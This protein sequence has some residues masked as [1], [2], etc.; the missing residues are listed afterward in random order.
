M[1]LMSTGVVRASH[2]GFADSAAHCRSP[3][4]CWLK[5]RSANQ[6]VTNSARSRGDRVIVLRVADPV[7]TWNVAWPARRLTPPVPPTRTPQT[8]STAVPATRG[9]VPG[10]LVEGIH[11]GPSMSQSG[12]EL[13]FAQSTS[14]SRIAPRCTCPKK[15]PSQQTALALRDDTNSA[16]L[17]PDWNRPFQPVPWRPTH[18][19]STHSALV[20]QAHSRRGDV[21]PQ[22]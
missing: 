9:V 20:H 6:V 17:S 21:R 18:S 16:T 19:G 5:L 11:A 1:M 12:R 3:K 4:G 15:R 22:E 14:D 7:R 10:D 13:R 8:C 2:I